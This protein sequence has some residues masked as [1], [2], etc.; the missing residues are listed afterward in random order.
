MRRRSSLV[1]ATVALLLGS[2]VG[3]APG[4]ARRAPVDPAFTVPV[5][6]LAAALDCPK[7]SHPRRDP[8]LLVHGTGQTGQQNWGWN[9]V[10]ALA[11]AG[12]DACV[13]TLPAASW[14]DVQVATEYV[15]Y[16]VQKLHRLTGR[17]VDTIGHSQGTL[18]Q[19]GS[20][21]WWASVR[22]ITDDEILLSGPG[23]GTLTATGICVARLCPAAAWQMAKGSDFVTALN[24]GDETPGDVDVT[25]IYSLV[26]DLVQPAA[27]AA[28]DGAANVLLQD[29]CPLRIVHH[30]GSLWDSLTWELA[31]DALRHDGPADVDRLARGA[32]GRLVMPDAVDPLIN[33]AGVYANGVAT[34]AKAKF[35]DSEPAVTLA[36][37]RRNR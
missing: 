20:V 21:K 19:R 29:V 12:Y 10:P 28:L 1:L 7:F 18:E 33:D 22:R 3:A 5:A 13:V 30:G 6:K 35:V 25:S 27:T 23:H 9:Y 24:A 14:G 11:A 17:D 2:V 32:C 8:V 36:R 4:E 31:L 34:L 15:A 37:A 16:A 26:D